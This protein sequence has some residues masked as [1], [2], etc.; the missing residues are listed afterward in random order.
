MFKLQLNSLYRTQYLS[1]TLILAYR[2][3]T[4]MIITIIVCSISFS[5]YNL[6]VINNTCLLNLYSGDLQTTTALFTRNASSRK[7]DWITTTRCPLCLVLVPHK[8]SD[9]RSWGFDFSRTLLRQYSCLYN[10]FKLLVL[11]S[12]VYPFL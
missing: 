8:S 11:H 12:L 7:T 1:V 4:T 3:Y 2:T 10:L 5:D 6:F 9:E